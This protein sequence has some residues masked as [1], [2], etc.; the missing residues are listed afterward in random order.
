MSRYFDDELCHSWGNTPKE[1]A[2]EKRYNHWYY[3]NKIKNNVSAPINAFTGE[4]DK[5]AAVHHKRLAEEFA[6]NAKL[7]SES[8]DG[9]YKGYN[10]SYW[11]K[12]SMDEKIEVGNSNTKSYK[13]SLK[14]RADSV[15]S[16]I[17]RGRSIINDL[18]NRDLLKR[19]TI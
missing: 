14:G 1:K 13:K 8:S 11:E 15:D 4:T 18:F 5:E 9:L 6:N 19:R 3:L 17:E 10:A 16:T 2:A 12:A 7:A